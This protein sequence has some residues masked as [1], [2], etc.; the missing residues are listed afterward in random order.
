MRNQAQIADGDVIT[1]IEDTTPGDDAGEPD[2]D[3]ADPDACVGDTVIDDVCIINP[4]QCLL[5]HDYIDGHCVFAGCP[6]GYLL[7]DG[8]CREL[9]IVAPC[10]KG[11]T[12]MGECMC[13]SS[14]TAPT[15]SFR[16]AQRVSTEK[17]APACRTSQSNPTYLA[18][19]QNS[20]PTAD[21]QQSSSGRRTAVM[22]ESV[23]RFNR[24]RVSPFSTTGAGGHA[25]PTPFR[26][27]PAGR[28]QGGRHP[29]HDHWAAQ[30]HIRCACGAARR[31]QSGLVA[32]RCADV[33]RHR[34]YRT[35]LTG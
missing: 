2:E 11:F 10:D 7:I 33:Y 19:V 35:G 13:R 24:H 32:R 14:S 16:S 21:P 3:P 12:R 22:V 26:R 27:L 34:H 5:G 30:C 25:R 23:Q 31:H 1:P 4:I 15:W 17:T 29:C 8:Q 28:R 18:L 9:V 20:Q 6:I